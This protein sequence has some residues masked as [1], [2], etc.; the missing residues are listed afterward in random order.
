MQAGI[1][2]YLFERVVAAHSAQERHEF[3]IVVICVKLDLNGGE[4]KV[5]NV[6][7]GTSSLATMT[8]RT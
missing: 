5:S 3:G 8:A 4:G 6:C 2:L 7:V 1:G